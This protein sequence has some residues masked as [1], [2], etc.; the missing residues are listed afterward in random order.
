M[1]PLIPHDY[2]LF[3]YLQLNLTCAVALIYSICKLMWSLVLLFSYQRYEKCPNQFLD[4]KSEP[5]L[6]PVWSSHS[7]IWFVVWGG[8]QWAT[9]VLSQYSFWFES[10]WNC[11]E[12]KE[13]IIWRYSSSVHRPRGWADPL[14]TGLICEM[15]F[16]FIKDLIQFSCY[17]RV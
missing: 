7:W 10:T 2:Y 16:S 3:L 9:R 17:L 15:V 1:A 14:A 6:F 11:S 13:T 5:S 8:V 12:E 4:E